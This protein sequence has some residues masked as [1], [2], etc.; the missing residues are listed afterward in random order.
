MGHSALHKSL[1]FTHI[2]GIVDR[3]FLTFDGLGV[4]SALDVYGLQM[5]DM[6]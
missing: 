1:V 6:I 5:R 2:L 3:K 4:V